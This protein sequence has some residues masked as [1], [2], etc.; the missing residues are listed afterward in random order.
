VGF[1]VL[2]G[3]SW[4]LFSNPE[5]ACE[6]D[7]PYADFARLEGLLVREERH[8]IKVLAIMFFL[9]VLRV[10]GGRVYSLDR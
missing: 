4:P 1:L 2:K 3:A 7:L 10:V 9:R 5:R 6:C 8:W